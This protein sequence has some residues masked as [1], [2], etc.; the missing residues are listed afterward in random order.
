MNETI[1]ISVETEHHHLKDDPPLN[2]MIPVSLETKHHHIENDRS[3]ADIVQETIHFVGSLKGK[4]FVVKL[5][6]STLEHQRAVLQDIIC[7]NG[8]S[9]AS[10]QQLVRVL[11]LVSSQSNH[12]SI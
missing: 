10:A 3:L 8:Q 2:E 5:G 11:E 6:G 4:K 9:S 1:P 7:R 12:V